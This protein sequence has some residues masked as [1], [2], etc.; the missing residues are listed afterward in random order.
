MAKRPQK[1]KKKDS[2]DAQ[3]LE[4]VLRL[5]P[6]GFGFVVP[7]D[8]K[9]HPEDIFIPKPFTA[10]AIDSDQVE[11]EINPNSNWKKGP[12]GKILRILERGR[13]TL[14]GTVDYTDGAIMAYVPLLGEAKNVIVKKPKKGSLKVGDRLFLKVIEWGEKKKPTSCEVLKKFGHISDASID[15]QATLHEYELPK[16]FPKEV[17]SE[18][19]GFGEAV[20]EKE[21]SG[22]L[23]LTKTTCITIDP[24]TAKDFDDALSISKNSKGNFLLGV[25]IADVA[26]YVKPGSE[27]DQ[28]A[29]KRCNSTYFPGTCIPMLPEEL[30][31]NL[32]SLR[33]GVVRLT[34][35]ALMEFNPEGKLVQSNVKRSYIRSM[36]RF[37]YGEAKKILEGKKQSNH[38]NTLKLME[39]LCLLLK[40]EKTA[41]GSID[42]ALPELIVQVDEQ[43]NPTGVK[44]E[45]YHITHQIVEEFMLKANEIV[46]KTLIDMGKTPLFRVHEEPSNENMADFYA[47]A[48]ALGFSLPPNPSD[49]DLQTLFDEAKNSP[50]SQQLAISFIRNLK[51]ANYSPHNLGHFGLALEHYCHFTSPIRRYS[52]LITERLLFDEEGEKLNLEKIGQVCSERERL[53]FRAE[54]SVKLL[55]KLRLLKSWLEENPS[56]TYTGYITRIKPFGL[57]F[58][59]KELFLEGFLHISQLADD[60]YLFNPT[61]EILEGERTGRRYSLGQEIAVLPTD[62]DLIRLKSE[63]VLASGKK[64]RKK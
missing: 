2:K 8:S 45:T 19:K 31:N 14:A 27:L 4:G 64:R 37:T 36:K 33:Q 51:L 46:A 41:R 6:R 50:F 42:F 30:S 43:G 26:H 25:H 24:D 1:K 35:S 38:A 63:W 32:C 12:D 52:D 11:V 22:R 7:S 54:V 56:G 47:N 53:S 62:V 10:D 17:V 44:I 3:I 49:K 48:R 21:Q 28:E 60:Y 40:K 13:S 34:V 20:S 18:A 5:H 29:Y 55:K 39:E 16:A 58:E 15:V 9:K 61:N 59:I 23:D 57:F